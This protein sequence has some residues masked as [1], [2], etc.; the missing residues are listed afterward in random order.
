MTTKTN[1]KD[2]MER[3]PTLAGW[4][5]AI[6]RELEATA[7]DLG[8]RLGPGWKNRLEQESERLPG[9]LD[10]NPDRLRWFKLLPPAMQV[11]ARLLQQLEW[12]VGQID[13][14]IWGENPKNF[15]RDLAELR[16]L[17][18]KAEGLARPNRQRAA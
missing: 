5:A 3:T 12:V 17:A 1:S 11:R 16:A 15:D 8:I 14:G 13:S 4:M 6:E 2:R 18:K 7:A 10:C 9:P